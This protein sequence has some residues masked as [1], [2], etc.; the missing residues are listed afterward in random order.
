MLDPT[1]LDRYLAL[2]GAIVADGS[3]RSFR[4]PDQALADP[5][6]P[7]AAGD[8]RHLAR[9]ARIAAC[10][11]E[12]PRDAALVL[13][14]IANQLETG[15]VAPL[16][17]PAPW[18]EAITWGIDDLTSSPPYA[19]GLWPRETAVAEACLR[20]RAAGY[21]IEVDSH[22][23]RIADKCR[24]EIVRRIDHLVATVGGCSALDQL[25]RILR[26][27]NRYHDGAW[28]FGN[29]VAAPGES[30]SPTIPF[31]W[32]ISLGLK[33]T[34]HIPKPN[35][36]EKAWKNLVQLAS[37]LCACFDVERYGQFE[38]IELRPSDLLSTFNESV[39]WSQLFTQPQSLPDL[40]ESMHRCLRRLLE[41]TDLQALGLDFHSLLGELTVLVANSSP[42]R[43]TLIDRDEA[44]HRFPALVNATPLGKV[45]AC[46]LDPWAAEALDHFQVVLFDA[47]PR[48]YLVLPRTLVAAAAATLVVHHLWERLPEQRPGK[49]VGDL[50]EAIVS[51]A[52]RTKAEHVW[53]D[54]KYHFEDKLLQIDV[55]A[56]D[57]TL[58]TIFEVKS[59][60]LTLR[61][62]SGNVVKTL[63]DYAGSFLALLRQLAR[64]ERAILAGATPFATSEEAATAEITSV[65]I[66]PLTF[67]PLSDRMLARAL[68]GALV[69]TRLRAADGDKEVTKILAKVEHACVHLL[70]EI[71]PLTLSA[72]EELDL[73]PLLMR[74]FWLDL[75]EI[76][77]IFRRSDTIT[78]AFEPLRYL[79]FV[80]RDFW[81]E[82]ALADRQGLTASHWRPVAA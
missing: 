39:G 47:G 46:F 43:P 40:V 10:M 52:C 50:F 67:G 35:N 21:R 25:F 53:A 16:T 44:A 26:E 8:V 1:D 54:H 9:A 32:L 28:L 13:G 29:I 41:P 4:P 57:D 20:L 19:D 68:L 61:A 76:L 49:L 70:D 48:H 17:L 5:S 22:G 3:R 73:H 24:N 14:R 65:A 7:L 45:N 59:K 11:N 79:T 56:R 74:C 37:D 23:S 31:G 72:T 34:A 30:K 71:V 27:T 38:G 12:A 75:G 6:S 51:D 81:T 55:A 33:H 69:K 66:S 18:C 42:D 36:P 58:L 64:H 60:S 78:G 80:S 63:D 82:V 2:Y 62:R 15:Q 77:Y